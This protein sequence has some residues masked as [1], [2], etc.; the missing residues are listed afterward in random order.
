M[1]STESAFTFLQILT[2]HAPQMNRA[3]KKKAED[4][5]VA[6]YMSVARHLAGRTLPVQ[7]IVCLRDMPHAHNTVDHWEATSWL[8]RLRFV[9]CAD[10]LL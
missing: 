1:G 4:F 8:N 2:H 6:V 3:R 5:P 9:T 7:I 10:L